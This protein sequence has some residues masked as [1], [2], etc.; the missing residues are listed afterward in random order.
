[1]QHVLYYVS[2]LLCFPKVFLYLL[3]LHLCPPDPRTLG[4]MATAF[5]PSQPQ[6]SQEVALH[7]LEDHANQ[8]DTAKVGQHCMIFICKTE[9]GL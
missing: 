3:K 4:V 9:A 2:D 6:D 8:I 5:S 1:M 7:L